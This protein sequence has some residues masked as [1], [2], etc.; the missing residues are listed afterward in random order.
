MRSRQRIFFRLLG[1]TFRELGVD[2]DPR[3]APTLAYYAFFALA[4]LFA[5]SVALL[6]RFI[7]PIT[8]ETEIRPTIEVIL[9]T[10]AATWVLD[11]LDLVIDNSGTALSLSLGL[12]LDSGSGIFIAVQEVLNDIFH[13]PRTEVKGLMPELRRRGVAFLSAA[14]IGLV[15]LMVFAANTVVQLANR[16]LGAGVPAGLDWLLPVA[17]LLWPVVSILVLWLVFMVVI[18]LM[19]QTRLPWK[20]IERGSLFTAVIFGGSA[21]LVGWVL[22]WIPRFGMIGAVGAV[23]VVLITAYLLGEVFVFGAE[24]T[25][26][27]ADYLRHGDISSPTV[28]ETGEVPQ[29]RRLRPNS[30]PHRNRRSS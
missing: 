22:G 3:M 5:L 21:V 6:G 30:P 2:R 1:A 24:F 14:S 17:G 15:F 8:L 28:R 12:S 23:A 7:D 18:G 10:D 29:I 16:V 4:P 13:V 19:P 9:P 11:L 27:Y 26:V 25:K 20:A